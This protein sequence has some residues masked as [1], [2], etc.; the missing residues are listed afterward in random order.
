[1]IS[2]RLDRK[3]IVPQVPSD[4]RGNVLVAP[5]PLGAVES[6]LID[7]VDLLRSLYLSDYETRWI[8]REILGVPAFY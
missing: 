1:V 3:H 6:V 5:F 4:E 7:G 2:R 8:H